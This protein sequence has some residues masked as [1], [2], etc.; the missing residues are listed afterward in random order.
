MSKM[1][2]EGNVPTGLPHRIR[3]GDK[4][5][6]SDL[7]VFFQPRVYEFV[8]VRT[9]DIELAQDLAQEVVLAVI[10]A[11]RDGR[12]RQEESLKSYVYGVARNLLQDHLRSR[13]RQ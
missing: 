12:L 11:L 2:S 3:S 4:A 5:A 7:F 9:G 8:M 10:R 6:E 1:S 13:A